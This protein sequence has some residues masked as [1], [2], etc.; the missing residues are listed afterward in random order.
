MARR[1]AMTE[2]NASQIE[3][4]AVCRRRVEA[5]F[6]GGAVTSDGGAVLL[7]ECDARL[8]LTRRAAEGVGD[9]RQGGKVVHSTRSMTAQLVYGLCLG[10]EDLNDH[11]ALR[12]D[13]CLQTAV[14]RDSRLAGSS[15]LCRFQN[16]MDGE[17]AWALNRL[18]VDL[19]V[20]SFDSPPKELVLDFDATD[21]PV[22]GEQV[23]RFFHGYYRT[24]CFLP[25]YVTCGRQVL[26]AYLR[27]S[28]KDPAKHTGAILRLLVRRLREEWPGVRIVFRA[29]SGFCRAH[30]LRWC[31][32]HEV[33]YVVGLARNPVL[34]RL[35]SRLRIRAGKRF[36]RTGRKARLFADIHYG[37]KTWNG[38]RRRVIAKAEHTSLGPNNRFVVTN[39]HGDARELYDECYCARGDMENRIKEQMELFADRT[40]CHDWWPNQFRLL[41]SALAYTLLEAVRRLALEGTELAAAQCS[42]IRLKLMKV[43]AVVV[44]NTRRVRLMLSSAFPLQDLFRTVAGRLAG[45]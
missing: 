26:A 21:I 37:A 33:G 40:S 9:D 18:L 39:L 16:R 5:C 27:P 28:R 34:E 30:V 42:T 35:C 19:F 24:Y 1:F 4:P 17:A 36:R 32:R 22:H 6:D 3:F 2:R 14:G 8:G 20:E 43:G 41:L 29:D 38:C 12:D 15:T 31:E 7:R 45:G 11:D 25:L 10:Y 23:G 44:R 13:P